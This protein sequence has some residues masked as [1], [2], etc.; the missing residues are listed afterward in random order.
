MTLEISI[1]RVWIANASGRPTAKLQGFSADALLLGHAIRADGSGMYPC[2]RLLVDPQ[3]SSSR[4]TAGSLALSGSWRTFRSPGA[5]SKTAIPDQAF[6]ASVASDAGAFADEVLVAGFVVRVNDG[7][8]AV[9]GPLERVPAQA[10][11]TLSDD[12]VD[13]AVRTVSN[14]VH[15]LG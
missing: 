7:R 15:N 10:L 14:A 8:D 4:G 9:E 2:G 5:N 6:G 12:A 11:M 3:W 1:L 13:A